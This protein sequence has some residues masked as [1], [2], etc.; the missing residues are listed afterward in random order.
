MGRVEEMRDELAG[1]SPRWSGALPS[2][3]APLQVGSCAS[4]VAEAIGAKFDDKKPDQVSAAAVAVVVARDHHG[5][6][7]AFPEV[8]LAAMRIAK[9]PGADALRL[10]VALEMSKRANKHARPLDTDVDGR[11]FLADVASVLP[12]ACKTYATLGSGV[13]PSAM[14]AEDSPDHSACVQHDLMRKDAPGAAYGQGLFRGVAGG[15]ALWKEALAALHTGAAQMDGTYRQALD[16]RLA[17]VDAATLKIVPKAVAA[18]SGNIWGQTVQEHN[19]PLGGG[20]AG[21]N[22]TPR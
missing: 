10:A 4:N 13:D 2:C 22:R 9:G 18:P 5:S 1:D 20:D 6:D 7:V 16:V 21:P 8:W 15:L 14:P 3:A 17:V 12:G 11:A 19:T